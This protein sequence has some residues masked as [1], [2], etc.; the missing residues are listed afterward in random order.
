MITA[1]VRRNPVASYIRIKLSAMLEW[2]RQQE[3]CSLL[4]S[5]QP[6]R[7]SLQKLEQDTGPAGPTLRTSR[8][9]KR[10]LIGAMLRAF[11][12]I[13]ATTVIAG[14]ALVCAIA[15]TNP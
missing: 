9:N 11:C 14:D 1:K 5:F 3:C 7:R 15:N 13:R 12:K 2:H 4:A 10:T 8:T 6:C